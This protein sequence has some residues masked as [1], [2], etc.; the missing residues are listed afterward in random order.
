MDINEVFLQIDQK[1]RMDEK[2][3]DYG[4]KKWPYELWYAKKCTEWLNRMESAPSAE[5]QIA[6][7][8]A[9]IA[10]FE[11]PRDSYPAGKEGYY[12]WKKDLQVFH[13]NEVSAILKNLG[14]AESFI[15]RV[16]DIITKKNLAQ[17]AD[18][19]VLEDVL[20]LMFLAYQLLDMIEK[21]P[22]EK[23]VKAI[24]MTWAKMSE[25]G[26]EFALKLKFSD[27]EMDVIKRSIA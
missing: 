16:Y 23:V 19:K 26:K 17:D 20:S 6:V 18:V 13:G 11:K 24:K 15:E 12:K 1:N 2:I 27:K 10:R 14:F 4:G 5:L 22:D 25:R 7:H 3:V 8:G 21:L 9:H